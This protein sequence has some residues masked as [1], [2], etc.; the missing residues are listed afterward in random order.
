MRVVAFLTEHA[1]V[2]RIIGHLKLAFVA[3][4]DP[5]P[6]LTSPA[7]RNTLVDEVRMGTQADSGRAPGPGRK[8]KF[9]SFYP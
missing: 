3:E 1:V 4:R 2:D 5:P 8:R 6:R 9:L 7:G